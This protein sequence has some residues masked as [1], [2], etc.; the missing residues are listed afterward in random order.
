MLVFDA[1][2]E[3]GVQLRDLGVAVLEELVALDQSE[4]R[5]KLFDGDDMRQFGLDSDLVE[6]CLA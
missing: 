3:V 4:I 2:A 6:L 1:V 5:V